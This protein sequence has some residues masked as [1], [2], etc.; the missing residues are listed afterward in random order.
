MPDF[1]ARGFITL[2]Q[3]A[4]Y[5]Y[6]AAYT[7][8]E[9]NE[10]AVLIS[11]ARAELCLAERRGVRVVGYFNGKID[12]FL[13]VFRKREIFEFQITRNNNGTV[14]GI[15]NAGAAYADAFNVLLF[16]CA[17]DKTVAYDGYAVRQLFA[18]ADCGGYAVL[19]VKFAFFIDKRAFYRRS[20]YVD[21][22][23]ES[24]TNSP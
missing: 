1:G 7:R 12:P 16:T 8:A 4:A 6:A 20:A 15:Y 22:Y 10:H 18:V 24:H 21:A 19:A 2:E 17:S 13:N 14:F 23:I 3:L 5:D 11:L 9:R